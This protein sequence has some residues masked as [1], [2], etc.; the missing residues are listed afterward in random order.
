MVVKS[1][2]A[3]FVLVIFIVVTKMMMI[4]IIAI[5]MA[6]IF[7]YALGNDRVGDC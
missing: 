5:K 2:F 1:L 6:I 7:P 4:K 3:S